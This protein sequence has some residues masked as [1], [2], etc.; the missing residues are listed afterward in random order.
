LP[1][2]EDGCDIV[3]FEVAG[4]DRK[5][6]PASLIDL[7]EDPNSIVLISPNAPNL[8]AVRHCFHYYSVSNLFNLRGMATI[9]FRSGNW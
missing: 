4:D 2:E 7:G 1:T 3:G 6:F 9:P 5:F 8:V